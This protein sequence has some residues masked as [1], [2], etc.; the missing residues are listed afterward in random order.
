MSN[1]IYNNRLPCK[2]EGSKSEACLYASTVKRPYSSSRGDTSAIKQ[3]LL[4]KC[5][6]KIKNN[7]IKG[8]LTH[9]TAT[10]F[11]T[12]S[13]SDQGHCILLILLSVNE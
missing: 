8:F 12:L 7:L 1:P 9:L 3:Q 11:R 10:K 6:N 5:N 13:L 4:V 2:N